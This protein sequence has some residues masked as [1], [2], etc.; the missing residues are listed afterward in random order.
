MGGSI[1]II[2]YLLLAALLNELVHNSSTWTTSV[3][4]GFWGI[5]GTISSP[6]A[7]A[8][9]AGILLPTIGGNKKSVI[10]SNTG[11]TRQVETFHQT[12]RESARAGAV[13]A[14]VWI[15]AWSAIALLAG[16]AYGLLVLVYAGKLWLHDK[17]EE[18]RRKNM[19]TRA[20]VGM[21]EDREGGDS[22]ALQERT[23]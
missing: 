11:L 18:R 21:Q 20:G 22:L 8:I 14:G 3:M 1:L 6:F 15:A 13:G 5:V 16:L 2:P 10:D 17:A 12:I 4:A 23:M 7:G 9:G 19:A